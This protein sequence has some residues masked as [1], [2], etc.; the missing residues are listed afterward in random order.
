M[1]HDLQH[2]HSVLLDRSSV[3]FELSASLL[4]V[5]CACDAQNMCPVIFVYDSY[6]LQPCDWQQLF[7]IDGGLRCGSNDVFAIALWLDEDGG[8]QAFSTF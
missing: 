8:E 2:I 5:P 4:K 7:G 1:R 3:F 6:R